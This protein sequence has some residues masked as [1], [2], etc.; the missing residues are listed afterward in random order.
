MDLNC[1]L[2]YKGF[3]MVTRRS[4]IMVMLL[5][6]SVARAGNGTSGGGQAVVYPDGKVRF[7]D[8]IP[9]DELPKTV[10]S[11]REILARFYSTSRFVKKMG[12][13]LPDF[14][15]CAREQLSKWKAEVPAFERLLA[16]V[17]GVR[18]IGVEFRLLKTGS[19]SGSEENVLPLPAFGSGSRRIP[20]ELQEPVA[21]YVRGHL[22][23]SARIYA[24]MEERDRCAL[25]VHESLRHLNFGSI[26]ERPLS[27]SDI[28]KVTRMVMGSPLSGE[29]FGQVRARLAQ[30]RPTP[31]QLLAHAKRLRQ[32]ALATEDE[33]EYWALMSAADSL[34]T[35]SVGA[36]LDEAELKM[37]QEELGFS[38]SVLWDR[39]MTKPLPFSRYLDV[40]S[41]RL[42]RKLF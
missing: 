12:H 25:G 18:P 40:L 11:D 17:D 29:V 6:A 33:Q 39:E 10:M 23:V 34:I 38:V 22:W 8:L 19:S 41:L 27:T 36:K 2:N 42:V 9:R 3:A 14:F 1:Q 21:S 16:E 7:L 20:S 28:E 4:W 35:Q 37:A 26:L 5:V 30:V 31:T 32:E 24:Q 15:D 13:P